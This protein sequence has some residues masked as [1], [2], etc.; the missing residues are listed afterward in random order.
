[1]IVFS[2]L[3]IVEDSK[4]YKADHVMRLRAYRSWKVMEF[5]IQIFQAGKVIELGLG[6]GKSRTDGH[7][8]G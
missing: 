3:V 5:N 8:T 6:P 4:C 1:M 2:R 7:L